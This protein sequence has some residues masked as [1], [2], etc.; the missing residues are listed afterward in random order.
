MKTGELL[1]HLRRHGCYLKREGA[2]HSLWCNPQTGQVEAVPRHTEI[3]NQLARKICR[4]LSIPEI[5]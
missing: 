3:P 5:G 1:R 2:A 4:G